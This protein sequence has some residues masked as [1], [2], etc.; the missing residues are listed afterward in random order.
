MPKHP[1]TSPAVHEPPGGGTFS[2]AFVTTGGRT[3]YVAGMTARD[4]NGELVG[5][6]DIRA[7]TKQVLENMKAVLAAA[8]ATMSDVVKLTVFMKDLTQAAVVR[9]VRQQYFRRPYPASTLVEV[10]RLAD[11]RFLI[12]IEAIAVVD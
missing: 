8:G 7:Q 4:R 3:V 1:V 6:G 10:S 12:E 9:E 5:D 2:Q 11:E